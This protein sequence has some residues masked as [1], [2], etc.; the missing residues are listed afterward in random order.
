MNEPVCEI[1]KLS[2]LNDVQL[3]QAVDVFI[4]GFYFTL[5][6]VSK[7]KAKLHI[8]FKHSFD[9]DMTYAYLQDDIV[10][11]FIGLADDKKR[12]TRLDKELYI[13]Q[14]GRLYGKLTYSSLKTS[15]EAVKEI[16]QGEIFVDY[17]TTRSDQ[18]SKGIGKQFLDFIH[19]TLGYK[20]IHLETYS[21][22]T[23]AISFYERYGFKIIKVKKSLAMKLA[24]F[25]DMLFLQ[26]EGNAD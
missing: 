19:L 3:S 13:Q 1:K 6:N 7:D 11:G 4:E 12:P 15:F 17:I 16:G 20:K 21:K 25:G 22:N 9:H 26:F 24:G 5:V 23:G 10:V 8:I 18:R 14:M 2:A